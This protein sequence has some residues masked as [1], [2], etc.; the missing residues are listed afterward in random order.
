MDASVA[1][2]R[3]VLANLSAQD[4]GTFQRFDGGTIEW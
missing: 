1:G 4:S 3:Q 2:M